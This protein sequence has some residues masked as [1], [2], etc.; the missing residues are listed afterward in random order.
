[1][2]IYRKDQIPPHLTDFFEPAEIGLEPTPGEYVA[3]LVSVFREVRR[4]LRPDGTLWLN[5]GDSYNNAGSSRNGEGL[6]G[7]RRG[8]AT[9]ADGELGYKKRDTRRAWQHIGIKHKDLLGIPWMVAFAL[10]ADGW[11]LRQDIIWAKPNPMP[12]SVRDRCTKAHE[13]VFLMSKSPRYYY[14]ATAGKERAVGCSGAAASFKR[15]GSKR[16]QTIPGQGY[17][18]HRPD[19]PDASY[20]GAS[21]NR[22]SVWSIPPVPYKGAHFAVMPPELVRRCVLAG[23]P[24]GGVVL[25]PFLGSGTVAAVALENGRRAVGCELNPDYIKLIHDRLAMVTPNLFA[26]LED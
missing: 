23:C 21:R 19:R 22:R 2:N 25:D 5:L 13:Y 17:G 14:D 18:T 1:M 9:G 4:V 11:Y 16:E 3:R 15:T 26:G 12:E 24:A 10:R 6:D 7:K 20:G 8:G